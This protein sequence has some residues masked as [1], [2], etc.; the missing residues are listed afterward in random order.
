MSPEFTEMLA[1]LEEETVLHSLPIFCFTQVQKREI[2]KTQ[3][4]NNMN[5]SE[6]TY[7]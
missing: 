1:D 7:M 6:I 2:N 5:L 3:I 4:R